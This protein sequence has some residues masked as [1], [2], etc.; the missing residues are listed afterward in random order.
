MSARALAVAVSAL[1]LASAGAGAG[2]SG[3]KPITIGLLVD[4]IG[5]FQ[6]LYPAS[7]AAAELPLVERGARLVD[8]T[9]PQRG[10]TGATVAGRPIRL[11]FGCTDGSTVEALAEAR[12]LVEA[13]GADL[14]LGP[15]SQDEEIV[16]LEYARRRPEIT[17]VEGGVASVLRNPAANFFNFR[18]DA[19][20]SV[21]GLGGYAFHQLGWRRAV[22]LSTPDPFAWDQVA[23]FVAEFCSLGG[24]IAKRIWYSYG[25]TDFSSVLD[26][27]PRYPVDGF[28][29]EG[30]TDLE[31]SLVKNYRGLRGSSARRVLGGVWSDPSIGGMYW[32]NVPG[33]VFANSFGNARM[34]AAFAKRLHRAFPG[35][36]PSYFQDPLVVRGYYDGMAAAVQALAEV[37]SDLSH[38]ERRF[39]SALAHVRLDAPYG[40]VRLD[41]AHQ[42]IAPIY[43]WR[44]NKPDGSDATLIRI[45]RGV[46]RTFGGYFPR[47]EP[48]PSASTPVCRKGHVP[49][50]ARSG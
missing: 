43:V 48:P 16:M 29:V 2:T 42:A 3:A 12:R 40:E 44:L 22:V 47:N 46:D 35:V 6:P 8:P 27:I 17:F 36:R 24:R 26:Q 21:A 14:L 33:Q 1:I 28:F 13:L 7:L 11:V 9:N 37:H 39:Q 23:G 4:C 38:G 31:R 30:Y 25:T 19:R 41:A 10:V 50:W 18:P 49:P 34:Q 20:Q 32:L 5:A 45:I 15:T